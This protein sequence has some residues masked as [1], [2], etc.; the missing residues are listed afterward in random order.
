MTMVTILR[1]TIKRKNSIVITS[2]VKFRKK[3]DPLNDGGH[4]YLKIMGDRLLY[5]SFLSA[6]SYFSRPKAYCSSIL[7]T[8]LQ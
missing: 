4:F 2:T 3:D 5:S 6:K 8:R 1:K 7:H